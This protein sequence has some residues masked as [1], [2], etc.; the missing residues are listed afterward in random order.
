MHENYIK[1]TSSL[2]LGEQL[3]IHWKWIICDEMSHGLLLR[4]YM[5]YCNISNGWNKAC[6]AKKKY[7]QTVNISCIKRTGLYQCFLSAYKIS[8]AELLRWD[9]SICTC[10]EVIGICV[11]THC[12]CLLSG[13]SLSWVGFEAPAFSSAFKDS[14]VNICIRKTCSIRNS[15][16]QL[17]TLIWKHSHIQVCTNWC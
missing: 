7:L 8:V 6:K 15:L 17:N 3:R 13:S 11:D 10:S 16:F 2:L 9:K 5:Y 12:T 14:A 4:F 1:I